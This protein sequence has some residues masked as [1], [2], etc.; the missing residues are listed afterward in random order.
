M[1]RTRFVK[2]PSQLAQIAE[3]NRAPVFNDIHG[4]GVSF[5]TEQDVIAELLPPPL[6]PAARP[7]V[8]L[9]VS[10]IHGSNCVGPFNSAV[11]GLPCRFGNDEGVYRLMMPMNT[12][13]AVIFGRE[14]YAEP[15]KLA[16]I[17][18]D[19]D[20]L[21]LRGTVTRHGITYI[22]IAGAFEEEPQ[23]FEGGADQPLFYFKYFLSPDGGLAADPEIIRVIEHGRLRAFTRGS[24]TITLR[25]SRHDPVIDIPVLSVGGAT[26]S[27]GEIRTSAEVVGTVSAEEFL[28]Y[29]F[30][31]FDDTSAWAGLGTLASAAQ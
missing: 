9:S 26:W 16:D 8:T 18:L 5:L 14:I 4:L 13:T 27:I 10:E 31:K 1:P 7:R 28:P 22:E 30:A 29:A 2:D 25:E 6:V 15:K 24:A 20:G 3:A 19:R 23:P 12:D 21:R 17:R 11:V